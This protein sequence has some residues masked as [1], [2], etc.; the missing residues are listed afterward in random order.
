MIKIALL[1]STGSIGKQVLQVV[2][3]YPDKFSIV[4][5]AAGSNAVLFSTQVNKF[6]PKIACFSNA[7][8]VHEITEIPFETQLYYGEHAL[9]HAVTEDADIVFDAVMGYAGLNAVKKAIELK[10]TVALANKETLVAGGGLIMPMAS[11]NG[12]S[13]IPVDSEHSAIWQCLN[14]NAQKEYKKLIITAS[15]GALRNVDIDKLSLVS[16]N[17]ALMHPNWNMGKKI[18]VDCATM[19]NKGFEVIEAMWL[20]GAKRSE[21]DVVIHPES[22]IHSMVEFSDGAVI[23]QMGTPSMEVPIQ[24]ALTYPNRLETATAPLNFA[25][26]SL[27]FNAVDLQRYPCFKIADIAIEKGYNYPC[28]LSG[29]DEEAVK[30]FLEGKIKFTDIAIYLEK[31][32]E[33]IE[34]LELSF[35]NLEYT[36]RLSRILVNEIYSKRSGV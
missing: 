7:E 9:L 23:S 30:L 26:K 8:R 14:F 35:E 13:I 5:M 1:G 12:V 16:P 6:K 10:K 29:A 20:F 15:G 11:K 33:K 31:V 34:K 36:D 18:T 25:G 17:D 32:L 19:L 21:I 4:S 22:I 3:R 28:A 2:E 24:L 27:T